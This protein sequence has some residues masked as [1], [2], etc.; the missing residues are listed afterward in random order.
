MSRVVHLTLVMPATPSELTAAIH[1]LISECD[2]LQRRVAEKET[3]LAV[4]Y[5]VVVARK[6]VVPNGLWAP[7][8]AVLGAG[9]AQHPGAFLGEVLPPVFELVEVPIVRASIDVLRACSFKGVV[10]E[11]I[12]DIFNDKVNYSELC[13]GA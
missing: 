12:E 3:V 4:A 10:I 13:A 1:A 7:A 6:P 5:R 8:E 9:A 11:Q 2:E